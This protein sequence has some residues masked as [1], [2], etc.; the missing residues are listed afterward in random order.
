MLP[1]H[2]ADEHRAARHVRRLSLPVLSVPAIAS[3]STRDHRHDLR[4]RATADRPGPRARARLRRRRQHHSPRVDPTRC[5]LRR[6]R[7]FGGADPPRPRRR[8]GARAF[9]PAP[10]GDGHPGVRRA[11]RHLRLHHRP[12]RVFLGSRRGTGADP[13]HRVAPARAERHR[14]R[15][16]QHP[17]RLVDARHRARSHA[18]PHGAIR[19]CSN[20]GGPGAGDPCVPRRSDPRRRIGPRGDAARRGGERER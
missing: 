17:A 12:R 2:P 18:L 5:P 13:R 19:R 6:H 7:L 3:G 16:L 4:P 9:Q 11:L 8:R 15:E 10:R 14:L 1:Y 20:P